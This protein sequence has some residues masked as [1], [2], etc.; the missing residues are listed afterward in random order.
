MLFFLQTSGFT[1][2]VYY[3]TLNKMIDEWME[4]NPLVMTSFGESL[5]PAALESIEPDGGEGWLVAIPLIA[6][7]ALVIIGIFVVRVFVLRHRL[8]N[9]RAVYKKKKSAKK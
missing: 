8:K 1:F 2:A 9:G 5:D 3:V 6:L 4:K 7:G